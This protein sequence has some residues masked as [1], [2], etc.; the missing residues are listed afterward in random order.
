MN[1]HKPTF[2]RKTFILT[3]VLA[4]SSIAFSQTK[5]NND[6]LKTKV[7]LKKA[8]VQPDYAPDAKKKNN[9]IVKNASIDKE[10]VATERKKKQRKQK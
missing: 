9:T 7:H 6:T 4:I 8:E 5:N 2:M 1:K 10:L 3:M